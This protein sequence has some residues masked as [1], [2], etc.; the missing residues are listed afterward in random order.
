MDNEETVLRVK[1]S[2]PADSL[3]SAIAYGIYSGKRLALR[4][5]GAA[6]V[7]QAMKA[8]AIAQHHLGPK[9]LVLYVRP[10]FTDVEMP[11]GTVTAM[12]FKI[13]AE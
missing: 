2:T 4:A 1:G 5:I 11:D 9:A 6:A 12:V 10:G 13:K 8:V 7:N 3:G